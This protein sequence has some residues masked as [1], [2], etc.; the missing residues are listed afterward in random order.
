MFLSLILLNNIMP[1]YLKY[2][3][4]SGSTYSEDKKYKEFHVDKNYIEKLYG[5]SLIINS[6]EYFDGTQSP[7]KTKTGDSHFIYGSGG[8]TFHTNKGDIS[9]WGEIEGDL[10]LK[11]SHADGA[12]HINFYF[13]TN[14]LIERREP[15]SCGKTKCREGLVI[16]KDLKNNIVTQCPVENKI[17]KK[18]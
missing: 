17:K 5:D 18:K 3:F 8:A 4:V 6:Y 15:R 11:K 1:P 14:F 2:I 12:P 13:N 16:I 9:V 10:N 7:T